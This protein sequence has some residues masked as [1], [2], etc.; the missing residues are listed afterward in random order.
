MKVLLL[1]SEG[2]HCQRIVERLEFEGYDVLQVYTE[3]QALTQL[4]D[5]QIQVVV[6]DSGKTDE[7]FIASLRRLG[8]QQYVYVFFLV[9]EPRNL[10]PE[11]G[12]ENNA[13]EYLLKPVEPDEL[14][15]RLIVVNRY[16]Q[17]LSDIRAKQKYSEPI[18]DPVTGTFSKSTILELINTEISRCKRFEKPFILALLV[19][20]CAKEI[21]ALYGQET[22]H[23]AMAQ[24]GLKIWATVRAYD[25]IGRWSQNSFMLLLPETM[26]S[27]ASVVSERLKK[28]IGSVPLSLPGGELIKLSTDIRF[29]QCGQKDYLSRDELI[30]AVEGT[31]EKSDKESRNKT[32]VPQDV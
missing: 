21:E 27:G 28:N 18:R 12:F 15:A 8:Y 4:S 16:S 9:S 31:L 30:A 25:L 7:K 5:D 14:M 3:D 23:K 22:L 26:L 6:L 10:I 20:N 19:L 17:T 11:E 29:V 32:E 2:P 24:V 1:L 13:D